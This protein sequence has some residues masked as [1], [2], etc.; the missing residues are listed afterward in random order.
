LNHLLAEHSSFL[1]QDLTSIHS[2]AF[3]EACKSENS[4]LVKYFL[5][6]FPDTTWS[7]KHQ[8][9]LWRSLNSLDLT[10]NIKEDLQNFSRKYCDFKNSS[11]LLEEASLEIPP[12][13]ASALTWQELQNWKDLLPE[14][15]ELFAARLMQARAFKE[16]HP[17]A[18]DCFNAQVG[19][20]EIIELQK[21]FDNLPVV[22]SASHR[23]RLQIKNLTLQLQ[24]LDSVS[25]CRAALQLQNYGNAERSS[26]TSSGI[27]L[28]C[29]E[30]EQAFF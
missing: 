18:D 19:L 7:P 12:D 22:L 13:Q 24:T 14:K 1:E 21:S 5:Y 25:L 17:Y 15:S 4:K 20:A 30:K 2:N 27:R 16:K 26:N 23:V 10:A 11:N 28:N 3:V 29:L 8:E 9:S 6:Q